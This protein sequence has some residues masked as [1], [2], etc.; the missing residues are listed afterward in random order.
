MRERKL[1]VSNE[2]IKNVDTP[3]LKRYDK[4]SDVPKEPA[5]TFSARYTNES[6]SHNYLFSNPFRIES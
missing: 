1:G 3:V 4:L 5:D 6:R 2:Y